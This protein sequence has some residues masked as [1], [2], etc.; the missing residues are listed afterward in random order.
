MGTINTHNMKYG[1]KFRSNQAFLL[2]FT[3]IATAESSWFSNKPTTRTQ[4]DLGTLHAPIPNRVQ[5]RDAALNYV[6]SDE[7]LKRE[8]EIVRNT[9][10]IEA[11]RFNGLIDYKK[12]NDFL[13]NCE[14]DFISEVLMKATDTNEMSNLKNILDKLRLKSPENWENLAESKNLQHSLLSEDARNRLGDC[15]QSCEEKHE[16]GE[17]MLG[18]IEK[19]PKKPLKERRSFPFFHSKKPDFGCYQC[20]K[21]L[22]ATMLKL[23]TDEEWFGENQKQRQETTTK[24]DVTVTPEET[25]QDDSYST[26]PVTTV[27]QEETTQDDSYSTVP[28]TKKTVTENLTIKP[29]IKPSITVPQKEIACGYR[30]NYMISHD[31][32]N[33]G[34]NLFDPNDPNRFLDANMVFGNFSHLA[35][36]PWQVSIRQIREDKPN[37][38]ICGGT[39]IDSK[40]VITS[41]TCV[42]NKRGKLLN[43][44]KENAYKYEVAV[45]FGSTSFDVKDDAKFG[46]G[47]YIIEKAELVED[48]S[49][50]IL[51]LKNQIIYPD[52]ADTILT[53][54]R[55]SEG[56]ISGTFVRP[57]CLPESNMLP[58][59]L[60]PF[61]KKNQMESEVDYLFFTGYDM[62]RQNSRK[63]GKKLTKAYIGIMGKK[64]LTCR[65]S[66]KK[67]NMER[68]DNKNV[69]KKQFCAMS[70][71]AEQK[72]VDTCKGDEGGGLSWSVNAAMYD[73]QNAEGGMDN[74]EAVMEAMNEP[75]KSYLIGVTAWKKTNC[76]STT[77]TV[78]TKVE[79]YLPW[80]RA[81]AEHEHF[82]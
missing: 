50:A 5:K 73:L 63:H 12:A 80:I 82:H 32:D 64:D 18:W 38:F 31:T 49:L 13:K 65:E 78:Y 19:A 36:F 56:L 20:I 17:K 21:Y 79:K 37:R 44:F 28:V 3:V 43:G 16:A 11:E 42:L 58:R 70:F 53:Q 48:K 74:F 25:T 54:E 40:T 61:T 6:K 14:Y 68:Q 57:I 39:L 23:V 34:E 60:V 46:T 59:E 71:P 69:F 24:T 30:N 27:T 26:M 76:D 9:E 4:C 22:P 55:V 62:N 52:E 51:K 77:P 15:A 81:E 66:L 29:K 33:I 7:G 41:G 67:L 10:K 72:I 35:E 8:K 47:F 75:E 1:H 45:G 2:L